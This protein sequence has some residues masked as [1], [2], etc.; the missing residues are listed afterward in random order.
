MRSLLAIVAVALALG[1]GAQTAHA[2]GLGVGDRAPE[3]DIAKDA[4]GR[5]FKLKSRKGKWMLLT[6]GAKWC[7]PCA[8]ELPAWDTLA[9]RYAGRIEFV[10][11]NINNEPKDGK[12]FFD[13]L[14]IKKMTRVFLPANKSAVDDLYETGTFPSSFI[15]DPTG[16]VRYVHR[17]FDGGSVAEMTAK[18]DQLLPARRK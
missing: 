7:A 1:L 2:D 18:L 15:V 10:A 11:V 16:L 13:K 6:F 12:K 8:K 14:K 5:A 4:K 3:L 17:G 9:A